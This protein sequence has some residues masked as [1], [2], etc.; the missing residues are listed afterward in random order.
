VDGEVFPKNTV[1]WNFY[2]I[3]YTPEEMYDRMDIYWQVND[4]ATVKIKK[5]GG[6]AQGYHDVEVNFGWVCNYNSEPEKEYDG[7]GLGNA[8]GM[9]GGTHKRRMLLVR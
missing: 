7:S 2:G 4:I 9:F 6:L 5:K 3:D 1:I 8:V